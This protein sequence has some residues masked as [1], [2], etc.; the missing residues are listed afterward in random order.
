MKKKYCKPKTEAI[1][2]ETNQ[3]VM[4]ST[5]LSSDKDNTLY[6]SNK[7][8]VSK[9]PGTGGDEPHTG[10]EDDD[11]DAAKRWGWY[12]GPFE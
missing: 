12:T 1:A 4:G 9:G 5:S 8:T 10:S 11:L 7:Q 3:F 2:M 6:D